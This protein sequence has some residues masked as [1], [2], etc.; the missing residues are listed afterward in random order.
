M[1]KNVLKTRRV[2][3][4]FINQRS[5]PLSMMSNLSMVHYLKDL[6][7]SC[8]LMNHIKSI[9]I[10]KLEKT[11]QFT[12]QREKK[13]TTL[14]NTPLKRKIKKISNKKTILSNVKP[15]RL[16]PL[17][18]GRLK[19]MKKEKPRDLNSC[20]WKKKS[21]RKKKM[22]YSLPL[23]RKSWPLH[24]KTKMKSL[25]NSCAM[26]SLPSTR[27]KILTHIKNQSP[28]MK[29]HYKFGQISLMHPLYACL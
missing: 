9:L 26:K 29:P 3:L 2:P 4:K 28:M 17:I 5:S 13:N 24:K 18:N 8:V 27:L 15:K 21:F 16:M 1:V 22:T 19:S 6:L 20:K 10:A 14:K 11:Y 12:P 7:N 25:L 23:E